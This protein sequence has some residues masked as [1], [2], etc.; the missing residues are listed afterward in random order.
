MINMTLCR[1]NGVKYWRRKSD[2]MSLMTI[3]FLL[4][5][6]VCTGFNSIARSAYKPSFR[7]SPVSNFAPVSRN[8]SVDGRKN[9][10]VMKMSEDVAENSDETSNGDGGILSKVKGALGLKPSSDGL[11]TKERLAKMGLSCLLSY[12]FVSNMSYC[13]SISLAWF[14]FTKKVSSGIWKR[15]EKPFFLI[16][17]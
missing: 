15:F 10:S 13:V 12:G 7:I 6:N 14:G 8:G 5:I 9:M 2:V 16:L 11:T 1:I 17:I 3:G 4:L